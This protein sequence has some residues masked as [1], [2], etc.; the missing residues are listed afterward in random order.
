[1]VFFYSNYFRIRI[2]G[3]ELFFK[4][5]N[6]CAFLMKEREK[7][8]SNLPSRF[9]GCVPF[10]CALV[11]CCTGFCDKDIDKKWHNFT[12]LLF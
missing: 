12:F 10:D 6:R 3:V 1:L 11:L 5:I 9:R 4:A 7:N 2:E 8:L